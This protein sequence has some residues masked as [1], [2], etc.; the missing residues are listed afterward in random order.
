MKPLCRVA[1]LAACLAGSAQAGL[2]SGLE[3]SW[4]SPPQSGHGLTFERI[5]TERA[6][7]FWHVFDPEGRPLTLY[8][9][10]ALEGD[11][12]VGTALAPMG[13]RFGSFDPD[14]LE[15]PV[16]GEV[17]L[18]ILDCNQAVLRYDSVEA[19]YGQGEIPLT[20]LLP[21]RDPHCSLT[22]ASDL[23]GLRGS[24]LQ[25]EIQ[26]SNDLLIQYRDPVRLTGGVAAN[27]H[28]LVAR[29]GHWPLL[30]E[31]RPAGSAPGEVELDWQVLDNTWSNALF[32]QQAEQLRPTQ[33]VLQFS[34]TLQLNEDGSRASGLHFADASAEA[35]TEFRLGVESPGWPRGDLL[36]G[37]YVTTI[38]DPTRPGEAAADLPTLEVRVEDDGAICLR[39]EADVSTDCLMQGRVTPVGEDLYDLE[40]SSLDPD[41]PSYQGLARFGVYYLV[42]IRRF[43]VELMASNGSRGLSMRA[44]L[45]E[46]QP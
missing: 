28:V 20:R 2:P 19:G 16:W 29:P 35:P 14:E 41:E 30:L 6:L 7:L 45:Q 25:A 34:S 10:A 22:A 17:S 24:A 46:D 37:R 8:I 3:G 15:L 23:A 32:G 9:E 43:Y 44:V 1:A 21:P 18:E 27:G 31:G 39:L 5:D 12:L 33:P 40:L 13:M 36:A 4:Y 38:A 42:I 26:L 11:R